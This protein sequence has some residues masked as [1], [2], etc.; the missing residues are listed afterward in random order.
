MNT[1]DFRKKLA[2]S[3]NKHL[4]WMLAIPLLNIFYILLNKSGEQVQSLVT[5]IDKGIPFLPAFVIPYTVWYPFIA[6][7]L[8]G[9][10]HKDAR[11]YFRTLL[12][13]CLSLVV[14]YITYRFFQTTV[15]RPEVTG[16]GI[17]PS[18]MKWVYTNDQ[19]Y[20]CFPSIHVLTSYLMIKGSKVFGLKTRIIV[21]LIAVLIIVST[22]F[23]KQHVLADVCAGI[24]VAE[25]FYKVLGLGLGR[26]TQPAS[27]VKPKKELTYN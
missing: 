9:M 20:N 7:T 17:V 2:W 6:L 25:L 3:V 4:L 19:P 14:C 5:V 22:L 18:L 8:V 16:A 15:P 11:T 23:V 1:M 21:R 10:L 12:A 24:F 26:V 27:S 13:L